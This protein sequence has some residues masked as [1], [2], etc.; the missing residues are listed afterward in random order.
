MQRNG[1]G[2]D[3][4]LS[5]WDGTTL[6]SINPGPMSFV[7]AMCVHDDGD[8][9]ALYVAGEGFRRYKAGLWET[10][11][12]QGAP[13]FNINALASFDDGSGPALYAAGQFTTQVP[14]PAGTVSAVNIVRL[15]NGVWE[16][17]G[18]GLSGGRVNAMAVFDEDGP[19]PRQPGLYVVGKFTTADGA[20]SVGIAR[21]GSPACRA[22][23]NNSSSVTVQDI[24]DFL[25]DWF[26][27]SPRADFNG[28]GLSVQ[29]IFDFLGAWF[30][31]C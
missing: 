21:W 7:S 13:T 3:E 2:P 5:R 23:Y 17:I 6:T 12:G 15:R 31:G 14:S 11:G 9:P 10:V 27:G 26:T 30:G 8:G 24:F 29:D 18:S 20:S 1:A 28:G 25:G 22:D 4:P 19:G 16:A